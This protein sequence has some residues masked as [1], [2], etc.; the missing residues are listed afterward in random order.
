MFIREYKCKKCG[1][2]QEKYIKDHADQNDE[3]CEK[4][5]ASPE[6]LIPVLSSTHKHGSWGRW[7]V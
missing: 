3:T 6:N 1:T 5:G 7:T 4:C 2:I